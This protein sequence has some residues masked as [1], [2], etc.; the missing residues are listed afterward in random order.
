MNIAYTNAWLTEQIVEVVLTWIK[1][2][3][4]KDN[5]THILVLTAT[6]QVNLS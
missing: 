2:T 5:Q 3:Q 4:D 1:A 6:A